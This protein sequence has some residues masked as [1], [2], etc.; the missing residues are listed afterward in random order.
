[1]CEGLNGVM[2]SPS[3][4]IVVVL[5][6]LILSMDPW[7]EQQHR[8]GT[9]LNLMCIQVVGL[10]ILDTTTTLVALDMV[11][12]PQKDGPPYSVGSSSPLYCCN[13]DD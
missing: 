5:V 12:R 3:L 10:S 8:S 9:H 4:I 7:L 6:D 13:Q 1:M 11:G 2:L